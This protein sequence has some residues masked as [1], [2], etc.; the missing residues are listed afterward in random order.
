MIFCCETLHLH[1]LF[2]TFALLWDGQ[3]RT[4]RPLQIQGTKEMGFPSLPGLKPFL[5]PV[6]GTGLSY[7]DAE[8]MRIP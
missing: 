4:V 6:H 5:R 7:L 3:E 2:H 8:V 1:L